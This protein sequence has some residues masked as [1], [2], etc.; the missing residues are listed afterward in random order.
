MLAEG[1]RRCCPGLLSLPTAL[2][3]PIEQTSLS[4]GARVAEGMNEQ[5]YGQRRRDGQL[6]E[7]RT[8]PKRRR[9]NRRARARAGI[10]ITALLGAA[11]REA[12]VGDDEGKG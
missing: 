9:R 2:V 8:G 12:D 3:S 1:R 5:R 4:G 7:P 10:V 6:S 11:Q